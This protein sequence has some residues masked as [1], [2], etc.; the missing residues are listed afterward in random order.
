MNFWQEMDYVGKLYDGAP[1]TFNLMDVSLAYSNSQ[2]YEHRYYYHFRESLWNEIFMRYMGHKNLE[3]QILNQLDNDSI[4]PE[5]LTTPKRSVRESKS[6]EKIKS[7]MLVRQKLI[8][9]SE[10]RLVSV[11]HEFEK[12][13]NVLEKYERTISIFGSA[14]LPQEDP[15]SK[16]AY[17]LAQRL[18]TEGYTITTGGGHGIM[19]AAN[20][21]AFDTGAGSIGF[22]INL[23]TEQKLNE[24]TTD[25]YTF[26][27]FFGRKVA[28]T[29]DASA[30][31][32]C[33]GGF[34]T[35]DEL[36]EI[37][38]LEQTGIIPRAPIILFGTAF[39][40][41]IMSVVEKQLL[42]EF[43]TISPPDMSLF[44]ITDDIEEVVSVVRKH[45]DEYTKLPKGSVAKPRSK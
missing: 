15:A 7:N 12:A 17:E 37:V 13:F 43:K 9:A 24:Y 30:Y 28:L 40:K 19:E 29:L 44:T 39:W 4:A 23:P 16:H 34:G 5:T 1:I 35:F 14:R 25:H 3:D 21:G 10:G 36:F 32:F 20:H 42:K 6:L 2:D 18:A 31:V 38:T 26:E 41:P 45:A 11:T 27:H 8:D 33:T 22:N